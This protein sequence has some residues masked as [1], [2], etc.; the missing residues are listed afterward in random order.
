MGLRVLGGDEK[1]E[2]W[3]ERAL[4][5]GGNVRLVLRQVRALFGTERESRDTLRQAPGGLVRLSLAHARDEGCD[6]EGKR[7]K[8][9]SDARKRGKKQRVGEARA[10][11][12]GG[13]A[14]LARRVF[15]SS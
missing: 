8:G 2:G 7:E 15:L 4:A 9:K 1:R 11:G 3:V 12:R 13:R 5:K 6:E 14:Q 10:R